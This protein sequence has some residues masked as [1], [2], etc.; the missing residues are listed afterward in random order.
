MFHIGGG[1][2][3]EDAA[4]NPT[5]FLHTAKTPSG[6][7]SPSATKPQSC[8]NPAP[9]F[10]P[11]GTLFVVC[12]H[13]DITTTSTGDID[14]DWAP[15]RSMGRPSK[16][17]RSGNWEDP[18]LW[19]DVYGNFHVMYGNFDVVIVLGHSSVFFLI[20]FFLF[21]PASSPNP[22]ARRDVPVLIG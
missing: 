8:N 11:N 17:S 15:L 10:H 18:Y 14:G 22:L 20:F 3:A 13:F 16:Y 9:A 4:G 12:D 21:F 7:W 5:D 19:F 1:P 2:S 6:P